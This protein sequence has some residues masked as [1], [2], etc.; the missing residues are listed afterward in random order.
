MDDTFTVLQE[1]EVEQFTQHLNFIDDN[2]KFTGEAEPNNSLAFLDTCICLKDDGSINEGSGLS[3]KDTHR[4]VF[5][6]GV[7]PPIR[8][9]KRSVVRTL[10]Q[11]AESLGSEKED[12]N[13]EVKHIKRP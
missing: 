11:R 4:P 7:K 3:E 1:N 6:L 9:P 13:K 8:T 10:L 12:K 2:S 5:E